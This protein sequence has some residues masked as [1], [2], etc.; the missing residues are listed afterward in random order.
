M[1]ARG[2]EEAQRYGGDLDD[3]PGFLH[4]LAPQRRSTAVP[5]PVPAYDPAQAVWESVLDGRFNVAVYR[6]PKSPRFGVLVVREAAQEPIFEGVV[7]LSYGA[8][9]GP[10]ASDAEEWRHLAA[11]AIDG[12]KPLRQRLDE[13]LA[14]R[15]AE[16]TALSATLRTSA[17]LALFEKALEAYEDADQALMWM[18]QPN[19]ALDGK[20]PVAGADDERRRAATLDLVDQIRNWD[21]RMAARASQLEAGSGEPTP[22]E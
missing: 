1:V 14:R 15:D 16:M 3:A 7:G 13:A 2:I 18:V 10:D 21:L 5:M 4:R 17:A 6:T 12:A 19:A 9:F 11:A 20:T 22:D 8:A